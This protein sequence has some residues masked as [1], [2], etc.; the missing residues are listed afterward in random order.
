MCRRRREWGVKLGRRGNR[1]RDL[2][3]IKSSFGIAQPE[4]L[5]RGETPHLSPTETPIKA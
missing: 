2:G 4:M 5:P 3:G 1:T